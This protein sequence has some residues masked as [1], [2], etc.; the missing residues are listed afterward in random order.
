MASSCV[1]PLPVAHTR[2]AWVTSATH[3]S[4]VHAHSWFTPAMSV[5]RH[6][7]ATPSRMS[8]SRPAHPHSARTSTTELVTASGTLQ[9]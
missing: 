6:P 1:W 7:W 8:A 2:S 3:R 9:V 5:I 4:G